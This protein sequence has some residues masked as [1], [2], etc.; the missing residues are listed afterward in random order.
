MESVSQDLLSQ[1][2]LLNAGQLML[3]MLWIPGDSSG[4]SCAGVVLQSQKTS[5][6]F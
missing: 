2:A 5:S 1:F 4:V 6:G 3:R